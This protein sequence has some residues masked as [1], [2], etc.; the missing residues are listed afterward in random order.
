MLFH[1]PTPDRL[2][3][4]ITLF[5]NLQGFRI[6]VSVELAKGIDAR[7]PS[8]EDNQMGDDDDPSKDQEQTEEQ[9]QSDCHWKRRSSKD[10]EKGKDVG[11]SS[12]PTSGAT[13]ENASSPPREMSFAAV[14]LGPQ[15]A[16]H[17]V[18]K[19]KLMKKPGSK[20]SMGNSSVPPPSAKDHSATKPASAP[21]KVK[22]QP[23]SFNQYGSD[24]TLNPLLSEPILQP[25]AISMTIILDEDS[26]P[27]SPVD[28]DILKRS[29]LSSADRAD[30]GWESP[31]DWEYDNETLAQKTA[32]LKKKQD[33]EV[34]NSPASPRNLD[35]AKEVAASALAAKARRSTAVISPVSGTCSSA[36]GKGSETM[37][38]LQRA[39][40]RAT[41][42]AGTVPHPSNS[43]APAYI[44]LSEFP[45]LHFMGI[46]DA[47]GLVLG[48]SSLSSAA[49]LSVVCSREIAQ[50]K[51]VEAIDRA[52]AIEAA[53]AADASQQIVQEESTSAGTCPPAQSQP[54]CLAGEIGDPEYITVASLS[55]KRKQKGSV[56]K[57]PPR[58]NLRDTPARQAQ[59]LLMGAQ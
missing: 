45:D 54:E 17:S 28:P 21:A 51:L 16:L 22:V 31:E 11:A 44:A 58:T 5:A 9:S 41:V 49:V 59:A 8:S 18:F 35:L 39:V 29:K 30:I 23:I 27:D 46:V 47:C 15:L 42:K 55:K 38:I 19:R 25:Q 20:S 10:K 53:R 43:P 24:L 37:P 50:A 32:K 12:D 6:G 56:V 2:P 14:P 34:H 4:S 7:P 40:N 3:R 57:L 48:N 52:A 13:K 33:G 1:S 36:R 26:A